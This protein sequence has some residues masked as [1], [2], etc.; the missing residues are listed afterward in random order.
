M[1]RYDGISDYML[2]SEVARF[3]RILHRMEERGEVLD[4]RIGGVPAP[5]T[6][7]PDTPATRSAILEGERTTVRYVAGHG[8]ER[9]APIFSIYDGME[10]EIFVFGGR[11]D[12]R[13]V[14]V[15]RVASELRLRS[16]QALYEGAAPAAGDTVEAWV[17]VRD[18]AAC[19]GPDAD[20]C[21][22]LAPPGRGW[23]LLLGAAPS[24][25]LERLAVTG[26]PVAA[27]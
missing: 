22:A 19:V 17:E 15:R 14:R 8:T 23:S 7:L 11:R 9:L 3:A 16:P 5:S 18:G 1:G 4:A 21:R 25:L 2:R 26:E 27:S 10:R 20:P 6:K 24:N 12:D 13:I